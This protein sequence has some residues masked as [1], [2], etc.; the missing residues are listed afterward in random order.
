LSEGGDTGRDR[1]DRVITATGTTGIAGVA[2]RGTDGNS[3][4]GAPGF[5]TGAR[6]L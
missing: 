4:T 2:D 6:S 5:F 3:A 1:P